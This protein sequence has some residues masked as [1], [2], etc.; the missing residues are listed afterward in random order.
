MLFDE[1]LPLIRDE[2]GGT[3]D[4]QTL[5]EHYETLGHWILVSIRVLKRR[6]ADAAGGGQETTSFSL[7]GVLSVGLSKANLD[8]LSKQID[9]LERRYRAETAVNGFT[10]S[11][12]IRTDR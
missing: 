10:Q 3:P 7:D 9:R 4:D 2:I 8:Q 6:Y 5:E 1:A 12:I 11:R